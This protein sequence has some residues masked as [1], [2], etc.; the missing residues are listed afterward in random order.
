M[1]TMK[2][3]HSSRGGAALVRQPRQRR[4][5][6]EPLLAPHGARPFLLRLDIVDWLF[7]LALVLG[8][9]YAFVH[10]NAHMDYYDKAVLV[11]TVPA[12]V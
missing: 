4:L 11:G 3:M 2:I 8:A 7:A 1:T 10:Y 12:L 6:A 5:A 9:G